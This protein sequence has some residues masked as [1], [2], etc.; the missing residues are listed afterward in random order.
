MMTRE[1]WE[2]KVVLLGEGGVGK[3][4]LVK[5]FVLSKYEDKY[6]R[7]MG[8]NVYKKDVNFLDV[9][10]QISV[11]LVIWDI[12]GQNIFPKV[13]RSYL[14]GAAGIIFV[15]DL[16]NK[17]SLSGII[18]WIEMVQHV[19]PKAS[20]M[21][22]GNK[23]DLPNRE[24]DL[25]GLKNLA[26]GYSSPA[27]LTSAKTGVGVEEAFLVIAK[28]IFRHQM[29][30]S[31]AGPT[32]VAG[33]DLP[34]EIL[35]EDDI[36]DLFGRAA[37]GQE[38]SIPVIREQFTK[39]KIDYENPSM[40]DL[41]RVARELTKYVQFMRGEADAKKFEKEIKKALKDRKG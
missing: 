5:R 10:D 19:I 18:Q 23:S 1:Q 16:T 39:L 32:T 33:P 22:L 21:F 35:A 24:F 2:H 37:G 17:G 29:V 30:E 26:D 14:T 36:I 20:Y 40:D 7:T 13:I 15:C 31:K 25:K 12:M 38:L 6:Q 27:L 41:E 8:T 3:T 4:S 28:R 11:K 9:T 34:K